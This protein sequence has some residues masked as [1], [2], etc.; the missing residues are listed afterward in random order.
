MESHGRSLGECGKSYPNKEIWFKP[1]QPQQRRGRG[2]W[3]N[4]ATLGNVA[5]TFCKAIESHGTLWKES[6]RKVMEGH[7]RPWNVKEYFGNPMEC[8]GDQ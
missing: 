3:E 7:K 4:V 2:L 6:R 5:Q 1:M 8:C